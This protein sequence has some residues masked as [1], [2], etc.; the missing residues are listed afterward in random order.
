MSRKQ[1]HAWR[2]EE[3]E[4]LWNATRVHG[5]LTRDRLSTL[6]PR[7]KPVYSR[8]RLRLLKL[9]NGPMSRSYHIWT[10]EDDQ[11]LLRLAANET[12]TWACIAQLM[13]SEITAVGCCEHFKQLKAIN[14]QLRKSGKSMPLR[15]KKRQFSER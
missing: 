15:W 2:L 1:R 11:K 8:R 12:N 9:Q 4:I 6:L 7:R 3:D 13:G 14:S 10:E 5:Q